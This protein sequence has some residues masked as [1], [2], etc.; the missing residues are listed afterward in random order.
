MQAILTIRTIRNI[1]WRHSVYSCKQKTKKSCKQRDTP[2]L[3]LSWIRVAR[4]DSPVRYLHCLLLN[5][6]FVELNSGDFNVL[7]KIS[8][9]LIGLW[10]DFCPS[11]SD[12]MK[13]TKNRLNS[14]VQFIMIQSISI[15]PHLF[16]SRDLWPLRI[17]YCAIF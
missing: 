8:D 15:L 17:L 14:K 16:D 2:T 13:S 11:F 3:K 7:N 6:W 12:W 9:F 5:E 1:F 10:I 4:L